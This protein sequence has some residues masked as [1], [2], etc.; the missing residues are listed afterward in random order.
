MKMRTINHLT[1]VACVIANILAL[2]AVLT[3]NHALFGTVAAS[4]STA[5][6]LGM[7]LRVTI[8]TAA[9]KVVESEN[10]I[11]DIAIWQRNEPSVVK[12]FADWIR[13]DDRTFQG[14]RFVDIV[15]AYNPEGKA[16]GY[17]L[18]MVGTRASYRRI[19]KDLDMP[20]WAVTDYW[21]LD[22]KKWGDKLEDT[23]LDPWPVADFKIWEDKPE[24]AWLDQ[25]DG[26][27]E[28]LADPITELK[29]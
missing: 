17:W 23:W 6:S 4:I 12:K 13:N 1:A 10:E 16:S 19:L 3:G 11:V 18:L 2:I 20:E 14:A 26:P 15:R 24:D 8:G 21:P 9:M 7:Y 28:E 29:G 25:E 5:V 22:F 27:I